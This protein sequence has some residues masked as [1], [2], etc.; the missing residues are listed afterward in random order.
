MVRFSVLLCTLALSSNREKLG[1]HWLVCSISLLSNAFQATLLC[2]HAFISSRY[3]G[4]HQ[5]L[6]L[7]RYGYAPCCGGYH[8]GHTPMPSSSRVQCHG[9]LYSSRQGGRV[10]TTRL[11][12]FILPL[13]LYIKYTFF[14]C[15]IPDMTPCHWLLLLGQWW[16][17]LGTKAR[18]QI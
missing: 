11:P 7:H 3:Q 9:Q 17:H 12:R 15:N 2:R 18:P 10:C 13:G 4:L 5:A 6:S 1:S 14:F 16:P 8:F